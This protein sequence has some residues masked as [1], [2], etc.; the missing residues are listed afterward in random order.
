MIQGETFQR[1]DVAEEKKKIIAK[2]L[3]ASRIPCVIS[4]SEVNIPQDHQIPSVLIFLSLYSA[5]FFTNLDTKK[6]VSQ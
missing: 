3:S 4:H 6:G 2:F 5:Q 1:Q